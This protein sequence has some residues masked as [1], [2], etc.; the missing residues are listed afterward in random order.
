MSQTCYIAL[1]Q[2]ATLRVHP[3][4]AAT[5]DSF[6]VVTIIFLGGCA[7]L[8]STHSWLRLM[9]IEI[10]GYR[11]IRTLGKGGMASVYLA[12]QESFE[13]EV[14]LKIMAPDL[15]TDATFGDRFLR[16]AR[17]VSRLVHPNIV[18]V[19]D[20]G[21]HD[22]HYFL[23]MEYVPGQ[24]LTRKRYELSLTDNLLVIKDIARALDF[25][26]KKGYVHRDV[27]PE[28]IMLQEESGRAV[29]MDFGIAR[30]SDTASGMT[31][32]GMAIG[33]PHYMSPEQAKGQAVDARADLY[34]LGVVLFLLLTG[35]VPYHADSAVV[36]GIMHVSEDI[37]RL[38]PALKVFQSIVDRVLAKNPAE[39]YQTG[40]DLIA[41][42]DAL[43]MQDI[44]AAEQ[45]YA[46]ELA[47]LVA[48]ETGVDYS[49]TPAPINASINAAIIEDTPID[50]V[51]TTPSAATMLTPRAAPNL[52]DA[53]LAELNDAPVD[54]NSHSAQSHS[55][56]I[57]E[58]LAVSAEDRVGQHN[59]NETEKSATRSY[60]F[61]VVILV[62]A[63]GGFYWLTELKKVSQDNL[64]V[65]AKQMTTEENFETLAPQ[66]I[67]DVPTGLAVPEPVIEP[68]VS[69][70]ITQAA[71]LRAQI[72]QD[73]ARLSELAPELVSIY[74][75]AI[76]SIHPLEQ[77]TA[78]TGLDELQNIYATQLSA[79][80]DAQEMTRARALAESALE[81]F[82]QAERTPALREILA[83]KDHD[84]GIAKQL[85]QAEGYFAQDALSS[86]EGA[87]ALELYQ[88]VLQL[89]P[90][91]TLAQSGI[92]KIALRYGELASAQ[93]ER[94][95]LNPALNYVTQGL[96]LA[97][98]N[99]DLLQQRQE[100]EKLLQVQQQQRAA[101]QRVIANAQAQRAA[102]KLIAPRGDN[103]LETYRE[104]L[105]RNGQHAAA[106]KGVA[107]I[108][109]A[110]AQDL[111]LLIQNEDFAAA[112]SKLAS[113]RESFPQ[114]KQLL[115]LSVELDE[116]ISNIAP[117]VT[118]LSVTSEEVGQLVAQELAIAPDRSI[119]IG[120]EYRNFKTDA[121][122]IQAILYD[123][124]RSHQLMQVPVVI[125]GAEGTQF[126]RIDQPVNGFAEGGYNIDLLFDNDLLISSKFNVKK[127]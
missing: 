61:V 26:G 4:K 48:R 107:D 45:D 34:S 66:N 114:S 15:V 78:Q 65:V 84:D 124:A 16:E 111:K 46:C 62:L 67:A 83:Y 74:R 98:D 75:S 118:R 64:P 40:A 44:A 30:I 108:E 122:V 11:I 22:G 126:F 35:R 23:S 115:A 39:R 58:V 68:P 89:E 105:V 12:I 8:F 51:P 5:H 19:Y 49:A 57:S 85:Q 119:Y 3:V 7:A 95:N 55:I 71:N 2:F 87:N 94:G 10:P 72:E 25:A 29:L 113:A 110:L 9:Q 13:R 18:T 31:Q 76:Q 79:A 117:A 81:L 47:E 91:N 70:W 127:K 93:Q 106:R 50:S 43:T 14:A 59:A 125:S 63:V 77:Q 92:E 112:T 86:P 52:S 33:T 17:I 38:P 32:T 69:A 21:I 103:A 24:D 80:I 97:A 101:E 96:A 37:P 6:W 123:G 121:S 56:P 41:D 99:A 28:N 20:V 60:L 36:V 82:A 104:L 1:A 88:A 73:L 53:M 90:D 120:F 109:S 100:L 102:G 54:E 42:I 27:K 116:A